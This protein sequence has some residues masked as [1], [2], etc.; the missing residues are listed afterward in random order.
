MRGDTDRRRDHG[1][2]RTRQRRSFFFPDNPEHLAETC[3]AH[4]RGV[5]RD[6]ADQQ[7]VQEH[8]ERIYV[9]GPI[10]GA[11]HHLDL[12]GTGV[13]RRHHVG[14]GQRRRGGLG[15]LDV[16]QL[17]DSEIQQLGL[18][19]RRNPNIGRL[20]VAMD[21]AVAVGVADRPANFPEQF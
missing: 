8:S 1:I 10:D 17:G 20:D 15:R 2:Q 4:S 5:E 3:L 7:F 13:I 19:V 6:S 18:A 9:G 16:E 11:G 14:E 21:D 12:L